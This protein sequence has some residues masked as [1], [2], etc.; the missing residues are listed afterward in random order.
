MT[1][2]LA[3]E[4]VA[5]DVVGTTFSLEPLRMRLTEAGAPGHLLETWFAQTLRDAFALDTVGIYQP[6]AAIATA[7]LRNLVS[8][9]S[10]EIE[11][12]V[13]G[14]GELDPH[15]DAEAAMR[16]LRDAGVR[17]VGLT[18]GSRE[19]TEKLWQRA[20]VTDLVERTISVDDVGHWKPRR[21]VYRHCADA[22]GVLPARLA[23]IAAHPWDVQG[24][25]RAG[26]KTACVLRGTEVYPEVME[27]P[28]TTADSLEAAAQALLETSAGT[29]K[30]G[31]A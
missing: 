3:P 15:P 28:D 9:E 13:S 27:P 18:N 24:A 6:F 7:T 21:E 17:V 8:L 29:T 22:V 5:F 19:I 14:F 16:R 2:E 1:R 11:D 25:R 30:I 23:L 10:V 12:I 20:G 4:V 26:L 31:P